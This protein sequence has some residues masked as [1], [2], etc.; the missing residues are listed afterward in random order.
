M[1]FLTKNKCPI[2]SASNLYSAKC[3]IFDE[4]WRNITVVLK[5]KSRI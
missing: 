1:E 3:G 5:D 2:N 4:I